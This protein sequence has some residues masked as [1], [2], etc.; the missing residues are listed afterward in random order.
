MQVVWFPI[1]LILCVLTML[2]G[3]L[4]AVS[5]NDGK[6]LVSWAHYVIS[7]CLVG[8]L[9]SVAETVSLSSS[10]P[11]AL[12][13][14]YGHRGNDSP[15][16]PTRWDRAS[17]SLGCSDDPLN[18]YSHAHR[19]RFPIRLTDSGWFLGSFFVLRATWFAGYSSLVGLSLVVMVIVFCAYLKLV[20]V[21]FEAE[22]TEQESTP[23]CAPSTLLALTI[24]SLLSVGF[25]CVPNWLYQR[26]E[27]AVDS[28]D[29]LPLFH[30][31]AKLPVSEGQSEVVPA[32]PPG[33]GETESPAA[34]EEN[35]LDISPS[36]LSFSLRQDAQ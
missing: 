15:G 9:S 12:C 16:E 2:T 17:L 23:V 25:G 1:L 29:G 8:R 20:R 11:L 14:T 30:E 19:S 5:Q 27:A 6:R 3:A 18:C 33:T 32:V 26:A 31:T 36:N 13:S 24:C 28:H 22:E 4:T 10:M 35:P 21:M 34:G 7:D